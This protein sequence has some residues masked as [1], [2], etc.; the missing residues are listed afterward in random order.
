MNTSGHGPLV[1]GPDCASYAPLLPL[2]GTGMLN[3]AQE[4]RAR[5][6]TVGCFWCRAQLADYAVVDA[7]LR[8][9]IASLMLD[10][11]SQTVEEIMS[12]AE[13]PLRK[14]RPIIRPSSRGPRRLL[15]G[16]G[17]LA[18]VLLLAVLFQLIFSQRADKPPRPAATA[19]PT[20]TVHL[21][22]LSIYITTAGLSAFRASDGSLRWGP[23]PLSWFGDSSAIAG[24][25]IYDVNTI[26]SVNGA[27][28]KLVAV[29]A[30]NGKT[31]IDQDTALPAM[32]SP[33]ITVAGGVIYLTTDAIGVGSDLGAHGVYALRASDGSVKWSYPTTDP[34][35]SN[36][37]IANG[38]V[39]ASA[40]TSLLALR[41]DD[42]TLLWRAPLAVSGKP[43]IGQWLA[44]DNEAVYVIAAEKG[45]D[46]PLST[47]GNSSFLYALRPADGSILWRF[48][49]GSDY[50]TLP[51][52]PVI[53]QG[54]VYVRAGASSAERALGNTS[55]AHLYALRASDG[56]QLWQYQ[57]DETTLTSSA[58]QKQTIGAQIFEPV[59]AGDFVYVYD[60]LGNVIALRAA[61]GAV[62]WKR[63]IAGLDRV[64]G[65]TVA[66]G[67]LFVSV[68]GEVR[69]AV[70]GG[71][72][73]AT[74]NLLIALRAGDGSTLWSQSHGLSAGGVIGPPVAAP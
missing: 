7:A 64:A 24:G 23:A 62:V 27:T 37:M 3:A 70:N 21:S 51:S 35:V 61:N 16:V 60:R 11:P 72:A 26:H 71:T 39:Y 9:H 33:N 6:H 42:G 20:P 48:N 66:G 59:V 36:P 15:S 25:I 45:Q 49:L 50:Y 14:K 8:R 22:G 68:S 57:E 17:A 18:A 54:V 63:Q 10:A 67:A 44:S 43:A 40:G 69:Q 55:S 47:T 65:L 58:G 1:P 52:A 41:A 34:V 19:L 4:N 53:A 74:P 46:F 29:D 5:R 13:T 2:L 56:K 31:V 28:T 38:V 32:D 30:S 12:L 73:T